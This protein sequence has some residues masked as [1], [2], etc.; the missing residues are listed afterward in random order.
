M[1]GCYTLQA[2][3]SKFNRYNVDPTCP[4]C[5]SAPEDRKHF[6]L[7]CSSTERIRGKY[8]PKI[9]NFID[10]SDKILDLE[11]IDILLQLIIDPST[12]YHE[13]RHLPILDQLEKTT[14]DM[15]YDIH[16]IHTKL[17][18]AYNPQ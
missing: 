9:R 14:R 17:M 11:N 2:N 7:K 3:R 18:R 1:T 13:K 16:L 5:K 10:E 4:N 12:F 6:I 15:I 8:L